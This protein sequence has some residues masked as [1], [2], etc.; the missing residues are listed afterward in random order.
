[1]LNPTCHEGGGEL[2]ASRSSIAKL[3][4]GGTK[5]STTLSVESGLRRMGIARS[6]GMTMITFRGASRVCASRKSFTAAPTAPMN[7]PMI[8]YVVKKKISR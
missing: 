3:F 4:T 1:M 5:P 7:A 6:Q 2:E 8:R